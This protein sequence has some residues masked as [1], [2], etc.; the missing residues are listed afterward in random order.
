[1]TG[2]EVPDC[3]GLFLAEPVHT[4]GELIR[5]KGDAVKRID[6]YATGQPTK[7]SRWLGAIL[8]GV[9]GAIVLGCGFAIFALVRTPV[10]GAAAAAAV[11]PVQ[12]AVSTPAA[13]QPAQSAAAATA[14]DDAPGA[15]SA[16]AAKHAKAK[17][18]HA[19][20]AAASSRSS[21]G[22]SD[23]RRAQI[24]AK[25]DSKDKRKSKDDLDRLLGL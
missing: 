17:R 20:V 12:P 11:A 24:L 7:M 2:A 3:C 25:H 23:Q 13:A 15:A 18:T 22:I 4:S 19:K 14:D 5:A 8:G 21:T 1:M 9:F 10:A 6:Y 16:H